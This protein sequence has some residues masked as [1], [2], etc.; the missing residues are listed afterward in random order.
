MHLN[1]IT[2]FAADRC[3]HYGLSC[4]TQVE[5]DHG[6]NVLVHAGTP[7]SAWIPPILIVFYGVVSSREKYY[8]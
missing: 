5:E 8:R 2:Q 1:S 3:K 7:T 4:A 6:S